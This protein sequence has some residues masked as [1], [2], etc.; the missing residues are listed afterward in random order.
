MVKKKMTKSKNGKRTAKP[1]G[2]NRPRITAS[3]GLD[4]YAADYAK[5]LA[6]PCRGPLVPG[7]FGDGNGGMISRYETDVIVNSSAT[8]VAAVVAWCPSAGLAYTNNAAITTSGM[9]LTLTTAVAVPG[10]TFLTANVSQYRVLSACLQVYYPGS[11]QTRS[12]IMSL[13][14]YPGD[15]L[16]QSFQSVDNIRASAQYVERTPVNSSEIVWRPNTSD[17]EWSNGGLG[18]PSN[19]QK[20][21]LIGTFAGIPVSTG[22]RV[23]L[24][25][26][27]EWY[28]TQGSGIMQSAGRSTVSRNSF[29]QVVAALDKAGDWMYHGALAVGGIATTVGK[30][31]TRLAPL[32]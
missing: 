5:L 32:L 4:S 28:P 30:V 16:T 2:N 1:G 22:M 21:V 20:S 19:R 6:D 10:S 25:C 27:Y 14:Q 31:V 24:V 9:A 15:A 13:G 29:A 12:G 17:L 7:P 23:R 8:D 18:T 26:V 11:E 3:S